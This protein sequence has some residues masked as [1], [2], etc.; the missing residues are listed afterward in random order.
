MQTPQQREN[1]IKWW[2]ENTSTGGECGK[3][4]TL[5][6]HSLSNFI[7]FLGKHNNKGGSERIKGEWAT[8]NGKRLGQTRWVVN[9]AH[10]WKT[11]HMILDEGGM[12]ISWGFGRGPSLLNQRQAPPMLVMLVSIL[13]G[14]CSQFSCCSQIPIKLAL[15]FLS[16]ATTSIPS[17]TAAWNI[18]TR[19]GV[20]EKL[21]WLS[22]YERQ[23]PA[24]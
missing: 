22:R 17:P 24:L 6:F 2:R 12:R 21:K 20:I 5:I 7:V 10:L 3:F 15:F 4:M 11:D 19:G 1:A 18:I 16:V 14:K 23:L 13:V 9:H 8:T